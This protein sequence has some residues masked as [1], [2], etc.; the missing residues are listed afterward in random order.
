EITEGVL[1]ENA[2]EIETNLDNLIAAGFQLA[3]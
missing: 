1:M 2:D 3:I